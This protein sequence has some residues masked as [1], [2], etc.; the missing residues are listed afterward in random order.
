M[1]DKRLRTIY[2]AKQTKLMQRQMSRL[3]ART[4]LR[5]KPEEGD[6]KRMWRY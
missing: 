6:G 3:S 1:D 2:W 4:R 5:R